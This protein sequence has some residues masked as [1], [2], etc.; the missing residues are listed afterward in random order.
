M[1]TLAGH[2]VAMGNA[3][4]RVKAIANHVSDD[5]L[6]DGLAKAFERLFNL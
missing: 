1:L 2:G 4:P 6:D 3:D 5:A